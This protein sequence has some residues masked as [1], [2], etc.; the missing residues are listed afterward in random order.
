[1]KI[2]RSVRVLVAFAALATSAIGI[3]SIPA[4]ATAG[5][6][7]CSPSVNANVTFTVG[8]DNTANFTKGNDGCAQP[9]LD[10]L[11]QSSG[12]VMWIDIGGS[13]Q[14]EQVTP[15]GAGVQ[16]CNLESAWGSLCNG[17]SCNGYTW[18][19]QDDFYDNPGNLKA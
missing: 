5:P 15:C 17:G 6:L 18:H 1:M 4:M 16:T 11:T 13:F 8:D 12:I 7:V 3:A 10:A 19:I 2:R 9:W 14:R